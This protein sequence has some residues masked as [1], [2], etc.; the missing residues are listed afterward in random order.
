MHEQ[1][2]IQEDVISA[3]RRIIDRMGNEPDQ[4]SLRLATQ[5]E[6]TG[7]YVFDTSL[8][9][10]LRGI[11]NNLPARQGKEDDITEFDRF[12]EFMNTKH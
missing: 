2:T 10:I 7:N 3:V 9:N 12:L 11:R 5:P 1:D 8:R 6:I 4:R